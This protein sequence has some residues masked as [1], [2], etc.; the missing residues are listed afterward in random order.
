MP[1][2][3]FPVRAL[4]TIVFATCSAWLSAGEDLDAD[5]G[6]EVDLVLAAAVHLGVAALAAVAPDL[7][8]RHARDLDVVERSVTASTW[9]GLM[10]ATTSFMPSLF[11]FAGCRS[12]GGAVRP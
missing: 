5:L 4:S 8:E 1:S 6:E 12:R 2:P 7:G 11:L 3:I 9:C 10:I